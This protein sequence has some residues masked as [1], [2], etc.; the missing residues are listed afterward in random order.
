MGLNFNEDGG[1]RQRIMPYNRGPPAAYLA[2]LNIVSNRRMLEEADDVDSN[3]EIHGF[4]TI[5]NA[6]SRLHQYLQK[7]RITIDYKYST[8]GPDNNRYEDFFL[9]L[10]VLNS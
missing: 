2:H 9:F 5:E 8:T 10:L 1:H 4:W 7:E 3:A 6:K